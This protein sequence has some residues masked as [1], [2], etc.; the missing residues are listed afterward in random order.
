MTRPSTRFLA[1]TPLARDKPGHDEQGICGF[2][3][4]KAARS[5]SALRLGEPQRQP[6][7]LHRRTRR[8]LAKV[9]ETRDEQ[10]LSVFFARKDEKLEHV[11]LVQRFRFEATNICGR[12]KWHDRD[13]G[14]P[15]VTLR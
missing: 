4:R 5:A 12:I 6:H 7:V 15:G 10:R 8:A 13:V 2:I 14:A 9:I 1:A 3:S 11:G